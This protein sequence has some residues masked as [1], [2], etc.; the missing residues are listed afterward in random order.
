MLATDAVKDILKKNDLTSGDIAKKIGKPT[1]MVWDRL[2]QQ[3]I[4]VSRLNEMLAVLGYKV[5]IMPTDAELPE[6]GY[7]VE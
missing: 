6:G 7:E 3:N 2:S 1:R 4:S 5:V